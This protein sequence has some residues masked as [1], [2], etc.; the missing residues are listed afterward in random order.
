MDTAS[1]VGL[2]AVRKAALV[3]SRAGGR[4]NLNGRGFG[5]Q[6][7]VNRSVL[8]PKMGGPGGWS[9]TSSGPPIGRARAP[10]R[11]FGKSGC[12]GVQTP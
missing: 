4:G 3:T 12:V 7:S 10:M 9:T 11:C 5:R 1:L 6:R 2:R 8:V